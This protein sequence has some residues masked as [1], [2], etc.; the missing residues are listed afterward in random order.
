[1]TRTTALLA[2]LTLFSSLSMSAMAQDTST[3]AEE[4]PGVQAGY[5]RMYMPD[6][7]ATPVAE[8]IEGGTTTHTVMFIAYRFDSPEHATSALENYADE[9]MDQF[10][11]G[12]TGQ[13][14]IADLGDKAIQVSGT[15]HV[16]DADDPTVA[17]LVQEDTN[18]YMVVAMGGD[19]TLA[20]RVQDAMTAI[21]DA[22]VPDNEIRLDPNGGSTGG[23]FDVFATAEESELVATLVPL[24]DMDLMASPDQA[25]PAS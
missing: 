3:L 17:L 20:A 16:G 4:L 25:T 8:V 9:G 11:D 18:V 1:M 22:K 13:E 5:M 15:T 23:V 14:E 6:P 2:L 24:M 7:E 12:D 19:E 10:F 21:I